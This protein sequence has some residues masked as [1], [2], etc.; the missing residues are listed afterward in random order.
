MPTLAFFRNA[1]FDALHDPFF[2]CRNRA[3]AV[4][5]VLW[6]WSWLRGPSGPYA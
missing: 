5:W 4:L 1:V 2:P 6:N 3:H